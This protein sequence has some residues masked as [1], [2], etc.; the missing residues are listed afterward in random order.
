[1]KNDICF[2]IRNQSVESRT[3]PLFYKPKIEENKFCVN[4]IFSKSKNEIK[5]N[6]NIPDE[7]DN[8]NFKIKL[9][10]EIKILKSQIEKLNENNTILY[11]ENKSLKEK[12]ISFFDKSGKS[13][14]KTQTYINDNSNFVNALKENHEIEISHL[15]ELITHKNNVF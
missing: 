9:L 3:V 15:K 6:V 10:E 8:S 2:S 12:I 13:E 14:I 1:M 5:N 7:F 11:I 4:S